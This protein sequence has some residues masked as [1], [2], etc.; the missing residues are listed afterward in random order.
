[1]PWA[2]NRHGPWRHGDDAIL[3]KGHLVHRRDWAAPPELAA[4][5]RIDHMHAPI[6]RDVGEDVRISLPGDGYRGYALGENAVRRAVAR[7]DVE[8]RARAIGDPRVEP[9]PGPARARHRKGARERPA[10]FSGFGTQSDKMVALCCGDVEAARRPGCAA[11]VTEEALRSVLVDDPRTCGRKHEQ[12]AGRR[13]LHERRLRRSPTDDIAEAIDDGLAW[14]S[15]GGDEHCGCDQHGDAEREKRAAVSV[16]PRDRLARCICGPDDP[17]ASLGRAG[18]VRKL[19]PMKG[20]PN[21]ALVHPF[22]RT[23]LSCRASSPRRS[24]ELTVPRGSSSSSA[25]SP[26]E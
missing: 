23:T 13:E 3:E 16:C 5:V 24:R 26:G 8:V 4:A 21:V 14:G 20:A 22:S 6:G 19:H 12:P 7:H 18:F 1:M 25:I 9:S 17:P 2:K 15:K 10:H 11:V